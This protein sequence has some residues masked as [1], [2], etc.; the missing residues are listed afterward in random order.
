MKLYIVNLT[1]NCF[2]VDKKCPDFRGIYGSVEQMI[3]LDFT[4]LRVLLHLEGL[5]EILV[6]VNE[7]QVCR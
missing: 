2:Q 3:E 6:I 7:Y 4:N 1:K 5:R